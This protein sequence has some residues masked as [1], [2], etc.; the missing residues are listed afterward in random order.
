MARPSCRRHP[1]G[2]VRR[3]GYYG[4]HRE[5]V[6]W[7]CVPPNGEKPHYLRHDQMGDLRPK[8]VGGLHGS[9]DEC[10]RQWEPTDGLPSAHYD[11]FVLRAKAQAL[12]SI[13]QGSLTLR[14]AAHE[15]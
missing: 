8:L 14:G 13:A 4:R 1:H 5:F 7:E 9:C 15:V 3:D 6:R 11:N 12:V 2:R 10:E